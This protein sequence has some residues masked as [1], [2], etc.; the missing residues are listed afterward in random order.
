MP[1]FS[2]I[3]QERLATCH[4]DLQTLFNYVIKLTDISI[5][6]GYRTVDEQKK[7]FKKGR[8][9]PGEIVTYA[10]GILKLSKHN[11]YPSMAVD[12]APYPIDWTNKRRFRE[13]GELVLDVAEMLYDSHKITNKINW[14]G[15]WKPFVDLPHYQ[16]D[17]SGI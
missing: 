13:L 12:V 2:K 3:S 11:Y 6:C 7:L 14:G 16:I 4:E 5:L 10:D 17:E 1:K 9:E 8:T 15:K